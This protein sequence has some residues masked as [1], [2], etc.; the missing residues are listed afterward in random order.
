MD[1]IL[2]ISFVLVY[3]LMA[4]FT[5][6]LLELVYKEETDTFMMSICI[7]VWWLILPALVGVCIVELLVKL[8]DDFR[9]LRR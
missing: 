7:C 5:C 2:R 1:F 8:A 9:K 3:V 4:V 6:W